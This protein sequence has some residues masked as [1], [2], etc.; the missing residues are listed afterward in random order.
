MPKTL[1]ALLKTALLV[2][3]IAF[4]VSCSKDNPDYGD[5]VVIEGDYRKPSS[6]ANDEKITF[7][8]YITSG[9]PEEF[10]GAV[11]GRLKENAAS[12]GDASVI[13]TDVAGYAGLDVRK[14]RVVIVYKPSA[15]LLGQLGLEQRNL[16]CVAFQQGRHGNCAVPVPSEGLEI[17]ESLNG[18]VSWTNNAILKS[19]ADYDESSLWDESCLHNTF[20][21]HME[22]EITHVALSK[23]DWLEGTYTVDVQVK[24]TPMHGFAHGASQA[25]DYYLMTSS[26]SVQSGK[27]YTG[28]FVKKHGGVKARICGFYLTSLGTDFSLVDE[29]GSEAGTMVQVP[30]PETVIGSTT[31]TTGWEFSLGGSLTGGTAP[32]ATLNTGYSLSSSTS[33]TISDCDVVSRHSGTRVGY[34]YKINNLPHYHY[35]SKAVDMYI[36]DPPLVSTST[37]T[38]YS[39]WVWSAP[40]DDYDTGKKYKL[41]VD[42]SNF[43]Y[44]ASY[45]YSSGSDYH[46]L[47]FD[48]DNFSATMDLPLPNRCPTGRIE[49][50]NTQSGT[51]LTN[52]RL[53]NKTH[54]GEYSDSSV[55]ACDDVCSMYLVAGEYELKCDIKDSDGTKTYEYSGAINVTSGGTVKLSTGYG[56]Q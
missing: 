35:D 7:P 38:F 45:F 56:F 47:R 53:R 34:D 26:V 48:A 33:R 6:I 1:S 43:V 13:V 17:D 31:Y 46:D 15:S 10:T 20:S 52:V 40:A 28:N 16:L 27:M 39:Q 36:T 42:L 44:G 19:S 54:S 55:Y 50:T 25:A 32:M 51:F 29:S 8:T 21:D 2:L 18:L 5:E 41:K 37:I 3:P 49:L 23:H 14:G 9:L 12:D 24:V 30:T 4:S 11:K 22:K